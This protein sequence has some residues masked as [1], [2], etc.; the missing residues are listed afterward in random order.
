MILRALH[1]DRMVGKTEV[2]LSPD[3]SHYRTF[4]FKDRHLVGSAFNRELDRSAAEN[5]PKARHRTT[6]RTVQFRTDE[7]L[8]TYI[9]CA[10]LAIGPPAN[11]LKNL[12]N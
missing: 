5:S 10:E 6:L 2:I 12:E 3:K 8:S 11:L 9:E 7:S 4:G 1:S